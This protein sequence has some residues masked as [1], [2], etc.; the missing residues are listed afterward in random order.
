MRRSSQISEEVTQGEHPLVEGDA[1]LNSESFRIFVQY[2]T[3]WQ[4]KQVN[5]AYN[6]LGLVRLAVE[7]VLDHF[8]LE[9]LSCLVG[10]VTELI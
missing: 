7:D 6:D 2:F 5:S 9:Q 4:A 8:Q 3:A 10:H 1:L